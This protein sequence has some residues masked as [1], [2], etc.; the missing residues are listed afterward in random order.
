MITTDNVINEIRH[1]EK[2][3]EY[4][5]VFQGKEKFNEFC[6]RIQYLNYLIDY[7]KKKSE[8]L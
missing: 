2:T 7:Y 4:L 1:D 5:L 8:R 6:N 3:D